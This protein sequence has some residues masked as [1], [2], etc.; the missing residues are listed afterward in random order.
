MKP[1]ILI[2]GAGQLGT[3]Y[4][5]G[6]SSVSIPLDIFV[7]DISKDS[8]RNADKI[9]N[10]GVGKNYGHTAI[11]SENLS[12]IPSSIDIAVIS[13]TA[14]SRS[15]VITNLVEHKIIKYWVLEKILAQN[16]QELDEIMDATKHCKGAW[17]NTSRRMMKWHRQ[18]K[19]H[20][21]GTN[22]L[23]LSVEG[24]AWG[25]ACN[26]IHF[27]DLLSFWSDEKLQSINHVDLDSQWFLSKRLPFMEINGGYTAQFSRG[28]VASLIC[29]SVKSPVVIK[30]LD[31]NNQWIIDEV[32]GTAIRSDGI[33]LSGKVEFQSEMTSRLIESILTKGECDLPNIIESSSMHKIVLET[34]LTDFN[35]KNGNN[36]L[37]LPIT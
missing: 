34:L 20:L 11:F 13:T 23:S 7:T 14:D 37:R 31:G 28:S 33:I 21:S 36:S 1:K 18:I 30:L 2:V 5:Q 22:S 3:R 10:E 24:G 6:L 15:G 4:L 19:S 26:G 8:L 27:L 29:H 25:L 12:N 35:E 17:V 16:S 32:S 9:W